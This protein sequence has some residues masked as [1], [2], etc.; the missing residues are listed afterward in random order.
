[1]RFYLI[2]IFTLY[3][4]ATS[5][6]GCTNI[7][8]QRA[9]NSSKDSVLV[10]EKPKPSADTSNQILEIR[11]VLEKNN[12]E[13]SLSTKPLRFSVQ[14]GAFSTLEKA[15]FFASQ[16]LK[17]IGQQFSVTFNSSVNLFVVQLIPSLSQKPDAE[18]LKTELWKI[19]EYKDAWIVLVDD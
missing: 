17:K 4:A 10:F 8:T 16:A 3:T 9:N 6:T 1:M 7:E 12:L 18:A 2:S 19:K 15:D 14:I 11:T 5:F 13:K